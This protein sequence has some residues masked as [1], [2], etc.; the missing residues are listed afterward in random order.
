MGQ[1]MSFSNLKRVLNFALEARTSL[2]TQ[3]DRLCAPESYRPIT[4][5]LMVHPGYPSFPLQGGCGEGPD[6][7]SQ[8][9][10]RLHELTTLRDPVLL[11]YYQKQGILLCAFNDF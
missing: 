8:S 10:D 1:N 5:E 4:A 3:A 2:A 7:F 11:S 9:S 6:D